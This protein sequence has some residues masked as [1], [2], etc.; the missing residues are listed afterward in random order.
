LLTAC[1]KVLCLTVEKSS[2]I[3]EFRVEDFGSFLV[4][5]GVDAGQL[6]LA[7]TFSQRREVVTILTKEKDLPHG[8]GK[9]EK[10]LKR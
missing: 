7:F 8:E 2:L 10:K 5:R 6:E 9:T 1:F 4:E 3:G